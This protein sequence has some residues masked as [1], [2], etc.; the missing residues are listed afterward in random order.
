MAYPSFYQASLIDGLLEKRLDPSHELLVLA[1]KIDWERIEAELRPQYSIRGRKAKRI[2]LMVGLHILKHRFNLSDEDAVR[3]VH[4][5]VYQ[6]A[7][8]GLPGQFGS[9]E[10]SKTLDAST[11]TRFRKRIGAAGVA[12]MERVV[13]EPLVAAK[14]MSPKTHLVDS[15]AMEKNVTYPTDT[16]LLDRGRQLIVKIIRKLG[17]LGVKVKVRD[18]A[19]KAKKVILDVAKLGKDRQERIEQGSKDLIAMAQDVL[20][21]VPSALKGAGAVAANAAKAAGKAAQG[22]LS[23]AIDDARQ[24]A[25]TLGGAT[26]SGLAA[27]GKGVKD[28]IARLTG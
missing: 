15:T 25:S 11:M 16:G 10:W 7:F 18:F 12:T 21:K 13:R 24:Q 17:E 28:Q 9:I 23:A 20:A 5:N 1:D 19:R 6:M 27:A 26:R 22:A 14:E 3:G 8:C 4:E 2:R